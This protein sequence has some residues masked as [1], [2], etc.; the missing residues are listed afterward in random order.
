MHNFLWDKSENIS[1]KLFFLG[2]QA[3]IKL[4][5]YL[6]PAIKRPN[7]ALDFSLKQSACATVPLGANTI[8]DNLLVH[9]RIGNFRLLSMWEKDGE[10]KS[11]EVGNKKL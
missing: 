5:Q 8:H 3:Y 10:T 9:A 1:F 6:F 7:K 11:M 4:V 2:F